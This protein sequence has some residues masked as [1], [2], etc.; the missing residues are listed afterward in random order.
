M[1]GRHSAALL[2]YR[3]DAAEGLSVFIGHMGGPFWRNRH[4]RAWSIPKGE[5]DP[6][7]EEPRA[8]ADREFREEIGVA[9]PPGVRED[10]G[11]FTQRGGK[12]VHVFA[13]AGPASL[14]F[15]ASNSFTMQ[16]PPGSGRMAQ[17]PEVD[18]AGWYSLHDAR[19]LVVAGQVA[20]LDAL[21]DQRAGS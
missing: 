17:F 15:V 19:E 9:P 21:A 12:H 13:V 10:L 20:A 11:V 4:Q 14:A 6:D 1:P 5:F 18:R 8:A 3:T 16:W 2:V 7:E